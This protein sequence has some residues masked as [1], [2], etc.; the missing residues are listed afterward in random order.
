MSS[1]GDQAAVADLAGAVCGPVLVPADGQAYDDEVAG[2]NVAVRR[3]P[4]V[5]VGAMSASDVVAAV[6]WAGRNG[7][8]VAVQATG[9]GFDGVEDALLLSTRRMRELHVDP[10][11]RTVRVGAGV[12]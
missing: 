1:A 9:H 5:V 3:R 11:A 2:F 7:L 12:T 4:R 8:P 10:V 6:R